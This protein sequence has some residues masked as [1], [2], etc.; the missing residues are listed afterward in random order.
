MLKELFNIKN[1]DKCGEVVE[2]EYT[3]LLNGEALVD[4]NT[5][6]NTKTKIAAIA[7][8][9][10]VLCTSLGLGG[11]ALAKTMTE[12]QQ[13]EQTLNLEG[14]DY[15]YTDIGEKYAIHEYTIGMNL[16]NCD[17]CIV[18]GEYYS[19]VADQLYSITVTR[20]YTETIEAIKSTIYTSPEGYVAI[21]ERCYKIPEDFDTSIG[22]ENTENYTEYCAPIGY[23]VIGTKAYAIN[24][25]LFAKLNIEAIEVGLDEELPEGYVQI[26]EHMLNKKIGIK[27][28]DYERGIDLEEKVIYSLPEGYI[29]QGTKGIKTVYYKTEYLLT[30]EEY[31]DKEFDHLID[32]KGEYISH[33]INI[34]DA[35]PMSELYAQIG[36][37]YEDNQ[38]LTK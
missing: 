1:K 5:K 20:K 38:K 36:L 26:K 22:I 34:V 25:N 28:E 11:I 32:K 2:A 13:T 7:L 6:K 17:S 18:N 23:V 21:G 14:Y 31:L 12:P 9:V 35:K 19:R 8:S 15:L 30:E 33:T 4:E 10:V 16:D 24:E 3:T 29:L 27:K 37:Q